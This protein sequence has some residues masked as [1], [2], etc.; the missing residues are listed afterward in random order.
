MRRS[1]SIRLLVAVTLAAACFAATRSSQA[2]SD[3]T[4]YHITLPLG[5]PSDA[6]NYFIPNDNPM[7]EAKVALG[8]D[9]FSDKQLSADGTIS[10]STCHDPRFAFTD[11]KPVAEGIHGRKGRRS[12]PT[13]LNAMFNSGQ[14]WDGRV[15][16]L[17]EQVKQPLIN[18]DEMGNDSHQQVVARLEA[19]PHYAAA[20]QTVFGGDVTMDRIGKA[21][22]AFERTLV[23]GNSPFD[24]YAAGER[25]AMSDAAKRGLFLFSGK[26]RC[27]VCHTFN[28][29]F[30]SAA[31]SQVFP[32]FTDQMYHNTGVALNDAAYPGMARQAAQLAKTGPAPAALQQLATEPAASPLGRFLVTGNSL[33]IGAFKTPSLRDVELTAPYF[34]DGS[35]K[36]LADVVAFYVKGGNPN[37]NRDWELQPVNLSTAEQADLVEFLKS[38]TSDDVRRLAEQSRAAASHLTSPTSQGSH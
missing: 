28:S 24:R 5:V 18:P 25:S 4:A 38:L 15:E 27:N 35:A 30:S 7:T 22:A 19:S 31:P 1:N 2:E 12:A 8:R 16:T 21:I 6:W 32:F 11:G 23:S 13:L 14:F 10:C 20:F 3:P 29:I 36:T 26:G 37:P 17:E 33:D 34:H 9:L